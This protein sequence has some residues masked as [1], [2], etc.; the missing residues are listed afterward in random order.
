MHLSNVTYSLLQNHEINGET[1]DE[2]IKRLLIVGLTNDIT[3]RPQITSD[4][5][6][7]YN[8]YYYDTNS[9]YIR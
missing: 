4:D 7:K 6:Q 5:R 3:D 9:G 2:V 1:M 8:K